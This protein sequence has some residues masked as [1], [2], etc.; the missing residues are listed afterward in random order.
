[1]CEVFSRGQGVATAI[2]RQG[3]VVGGQVGVDVGKQSTGY[4]LLLKLQAACLGFG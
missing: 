3:F 1:M 2:D 4:V